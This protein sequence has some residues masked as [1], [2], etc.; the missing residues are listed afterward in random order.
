MASNLRFRERAA[1]VNDAVVSGTAL[2][3][4]L[5]KKRKKER[6]SPIARS[7]GLG[8]RR[9]HPSAP[10]SSLFFVSTLSALKIMS[11]CA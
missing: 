8:E 11:E 1:V 4:G 3:A 5:G 2:C 9:R 10:L 7:E 6:G